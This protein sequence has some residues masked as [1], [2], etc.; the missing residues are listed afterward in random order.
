MTDAKDNEG[1]ADITGA[2]ITG[3]GPEDGPAQSSTTEDGP[4]GPG[5]LEPEVDAAFASLGLSAAAVKPYRDSY[6][7]CLAGVP[8]SQD[9]DVGHD[10]CRIGLLRAMKAGVTLKDEAW[11]AFGQKLEAIESELTSDL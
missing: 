10:A 2:D 3:T 8:R 6:L 9:L 5:W 1:S 11:Q 4:S 7:D